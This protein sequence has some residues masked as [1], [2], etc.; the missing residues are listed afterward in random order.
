MVRGER[1]TPHSMSLTVRVL[2]PARSA[3]ASCESRDLMRKS[4]S[5]SARL[6]DSVMSLCWLPICEESSRIFVVTQSGACYARPM[7]PGPLDDD[8][9]PL[10]TPQRA[11]C[12]G[13]QDAES[14]SQD[15]K[16]DSRGSK[17]PSLKV[18]RAVRD[19]VE[20]LRR[21]QHGARRRG[22]RRRRT[23]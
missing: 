7:T 17:A 16:D 1:A 9:P 6:A 11:A 3:R 5:R 13:R 19:S 8:L 23:R 18:D 12:R 20:E 4:R 21:R 14:T 10:L 15:E 2:T 22:I